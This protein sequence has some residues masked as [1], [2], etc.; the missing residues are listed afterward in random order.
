MTY[1]QAEA[2]AALEQL[3]ED[4]VTAMQAGDATRGAQ[5]AEAA[6]QLA[7]WIEQG[8]PGEPPPPAEGDLLAQD[9]LLPQEAQ[10]PQG[11]QLTQGEPLAEEAPD[12]SDQRLAVLTLRLL[13]SP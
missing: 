6:A 9:D 8:M 5:L 10:L 4:F 11:A 13:A 1:T 3:K 12:A 7:A 2:H